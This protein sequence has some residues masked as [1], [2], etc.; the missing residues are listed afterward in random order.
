[1]NK[2]LY[3]QKR[4][5]EMENIPSACI[6]SYEQAKELVKRALVEN[7]QYPVD[8]WRICLRA[9]E[10]SDNPDM[11]IPMELFKLVVTYINVIR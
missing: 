7:K 1:M 4:L 3:E 11:F 2:E 8:A 5:I 10:I 6:P 9:E